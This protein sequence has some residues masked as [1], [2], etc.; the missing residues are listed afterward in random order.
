M[1][2]TKKTERTFEVVLEL[3]YIDKD[4]G[5]VLRD[6][7]GVVGGIEEAKALYQRMLASRDTHASIVALAIGY[8]QWMEHGCGADFFEWYAANNEDG[9]FRYLAT[10]L[11]RMVKRRGEDS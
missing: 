8:G 7:I 11:E 3:R 4:R 2:E 6:G 10:E 9:T 1:S 5:A